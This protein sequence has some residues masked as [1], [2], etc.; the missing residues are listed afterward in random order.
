MKIK[1]VL[2]VLILALILFAIVI[3]AMKPLE[4]GSITVQNN[5]SESI[6]S[7]TINVDG[8]KIDFGEILVGQSKTLQFSTPEA[9]KIKC[10]AKF[11]DGK[12]YNGDNNG[13]YNNQTDSI[14]FIFTGASDRTAEM[15]LTYTSADKK[16]SWSKLFK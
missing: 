2:V 16:T 10:L 15:G 3:V 7:L 6:N 8:E 9:L 1:K 4:N 5:Y 14:S 11:S 12:V 13:H